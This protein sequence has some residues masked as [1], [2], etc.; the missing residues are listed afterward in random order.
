MAGAE[1]QVLDG[2]VCIRGDLVMEGYEHEGLEADD[3]NCDAWTGGQKGKG[4]L[5]TGHL[6]EEIGLLRA[7]RGDLGH[8]E[9]RRH[10]QLRMQEPRTKMVGSTSLAA[11]RR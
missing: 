1:I 8:L 10:K 2:E 4:F 9:P 6:A 3:P 7:A 11:V 5:R